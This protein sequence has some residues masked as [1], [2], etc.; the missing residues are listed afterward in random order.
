[1]TVAE[2][3]SISKSKSKAKVKAIPG[4]ASRPSSWVCPCVGLASFFFPGACVG[5][6]IK[7]AVQTP[8]KKMVNNS[9]SSVYSLLE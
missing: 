6:S 2:T 4:P 7:A 5:A 1:M 3:K 8:K 9:N